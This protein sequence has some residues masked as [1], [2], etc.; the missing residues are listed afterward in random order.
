MVTVPFTSKFPFIFK[1]PPIVVI[2]I[3][4]KFATSAVP[5]VFVSTKSANPRNCDK[6]ENVETP[7]TIRSYK[8]VVP[9]D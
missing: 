1:F 7:A 9:E 6:P 4:F 8:F 3:T 5:E 2:P